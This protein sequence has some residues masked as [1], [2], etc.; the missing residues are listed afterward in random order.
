MNTNGEI[1]SKIRNANK[2][3]SKDDKLSD[4]WV[5]ASAYDIVKRLMKQGNNLVKAYKSD[6]IFQYLPCIKMTCVDIS[7]CTS[8]SSGVKV[9]KSV[10]KL[11]EIETGL[12]G[13]LIQRVVTIDGTDISKTTAREYSS[14]SNMKYAANKL[15]Y[16]IQNGYLYISNPEIELVNMSAYFK[17]YL[18]TEEDGCPDPYGR[19]FLCPEWLIDETLQI[20]N[21]ELQ[22]L[23][24]YRDDNGSDNQDKSK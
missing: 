2:F 5:L 20:L 6:E 8:I 4:R 16:W 12:N 1:I 14:I 24:S 17:D 15:Y 19:K 9:A 21:K 11:P 23:H 18:E 3:I 10:N 22:P 13:F 7:E